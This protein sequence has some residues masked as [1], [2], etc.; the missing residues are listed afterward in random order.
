MNRVSPIEQFDAMARD[1][2]PSCD[3]VQNLLAAAGDDQRA[4]E[5]H[6]VHWCNQ[7][8]LDLTPFGL[9]GGMVYVYSDGAARLARIARGVYWVYASQAV[10][11][12]ADPRY[13]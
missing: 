7:H 2:V 11:T 12:H 5:D 9:H 3:T 10:E 13:A 6:I 8:D 4:L 1:S